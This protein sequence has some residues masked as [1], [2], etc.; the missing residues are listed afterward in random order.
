MFFQVHK[1]FYYQNFVIRIAMQ[2]Q[3][4]Q[5]EKGKNVSVVN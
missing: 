5:K 2:T 4:T 1:F 3:Y